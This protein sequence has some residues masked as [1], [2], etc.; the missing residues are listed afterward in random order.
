MMNSEKKKFKFGL[1]DLAII[2]AVAACAVGIAIRFNVAEKFLAS[3]DI[4]EVEISFYLRD[5]AP[6]SA[7]AV[8]VGDTVYWQNDAMGTI[9]S[10][11]VY[12]AEAM[13]ERFDGTVVKTENPE[14]RDV[15][16]IITAKGR[17]TKDGFMLN[18]S[19]YIAAGKSIGVKTMHVHADILITGIKVLN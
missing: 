16:G 2:L 8:M 4:S 7:S 14:R 5:I 13:L 19:T 11:E 12:N 17:V 6:T 15:R 9:K 18:G 3:S 1:I 10:I